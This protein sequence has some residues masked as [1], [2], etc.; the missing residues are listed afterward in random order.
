MICSGV[1]ARTALLMPA[2]SAISAMQSI[3]QI[4]AFCMFVS[5]FLNDH[6]ARVRRA[7]LARR[8]ACVAIRSVP[9]VSAEA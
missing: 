3:L 2:V 4:D 7:S 6:G 5:F 1:I 9:P 8:I